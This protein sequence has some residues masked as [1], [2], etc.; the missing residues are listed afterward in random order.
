MGS[1][2]QIVS[3]ENVEL[4]PTMTSFFLLTDWYKG[5]W[6]SEMFPNSETESEKNIYEFTMLVQ[7]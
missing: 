5:S 2:V 6:I 7:Y 4:I 3:E 1:D